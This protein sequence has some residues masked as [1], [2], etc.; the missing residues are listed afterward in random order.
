MVG[1]TGVS[2]LILKYPN[3]KFSISVN[4]RA[5]SSSVDVALLAVIWLAIKKYPRN[6]KLKEMQ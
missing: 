4:T 1:Y 6:E 3:P 5:S 2:T